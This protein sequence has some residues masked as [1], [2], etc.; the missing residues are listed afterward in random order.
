[1]RA[2]Q[3]ERPLSA[4]AVPSGQ[5]TLDVVTVALPS[6]AAAAT[7]AESLYA[8]CF[9]SDPRSFWLDSAR[10]RRP[11]P[12]RPTHHPRNQPHLATD[13]ASTIPDRAGTEPLLLPRRQ[14]WAGKVRSARPTS[15]TLPLQQS[16]NPHHAALAL[17]WSVLLSM[18]LEYAV[19]GRTARLHA[20][21]STCVHAHV[22]AAGPDGLAVPLPTQTDLLALLESLALP[23]LL[24]VSAHIE[25]PFVGGWVGYLGYELDGPERAPLPPSALATPADAAVPTAHLVF[26]D[27]LLAVD[28]LTANVHVLSLR[29]PALPALN[30]A[31]A[32]W[33]TAMA[34]RVRALA[35]DPT[36][37]AALPIDRDGRCAFFVCPS[38]EGAPRS[39]G[40]AAGGADEQR[41]WQC[42]KPWSAA[43]GRRTAPP[44]PPS[45]ARDP[46]CGC[47]GPRTSPRCVR[48]SRPS[49]KARATRSASRRKSPTTC[50]SR[51]VA[52]RPT[53]DEQI[54]Q[55]HAR[56]RMAGWSVGVAAA[57]AGRVPLP[58]AHQSGA[59]RRVL[60]LWPVLCRA[61]VF[62]RTVRAPWPIRGRLTRRRR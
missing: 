32:A 33:A 8:A 20:P 24:T 56:E 59:L 27:R 41:S 62:A 31:N 52:E 57:A 25:T 48:R 9:A 42:A 17:V 36:P 21:A 23:L 16:H 14:R 55:A 47:P 61:V 40:R 26:A 3:P 60:A 53:V 43:C 50:L 58:A 37:P 10:V 35:A 46:R 49:S 34:E 5:A 30:A 13:P 45:P 51:S 6:A 19:K 7:A 54:C 2:N 29:H 28:H 44:L 1:M 22:V 4:V 39:R 11:P 18:S 15:V 12:C 38:P